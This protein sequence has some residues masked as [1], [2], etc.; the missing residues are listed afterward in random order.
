[1]PAEDPASVPTYVNS[2]SAPF[3]YF[4]VVATYGHINGAIQVD[5][6]AARLTASACWRVPW[7]ISQSRTYFSQ[8]RHAS[9]PQHYI[10]LQRVENV[11]FVLHQGENEQPAKEVATPA[12]DKPEWRSGSEVTH[13]ARP[14]TSPAL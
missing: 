3:I 11:S 8:R 9:M 1:M 10:P 5:L 7:A 2:P 4:D 12:R 6:A 14:P 13:V